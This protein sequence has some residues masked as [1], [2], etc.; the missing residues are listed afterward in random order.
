MKYIHICAAT[1][2]KPG[3]PASHRLPLLHCAALGGAVDVEQLVAFVD[4][5]HDLLLAVDS[6]V[7]EE[8]RALADQLGVDVDA[9]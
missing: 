8:M 2:I 9:S 5:G 7:S 1:L 6:S 3:S 4:A